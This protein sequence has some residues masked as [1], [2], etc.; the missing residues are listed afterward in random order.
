MNERSWSC[1]VV[2]IYITSNIISFATSLY[3]TRGVIDT[4][5]TKIGDRKSNL[6]DELIDEE[7]RRSKIVTLSL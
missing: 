1:T 4:T 7:T 3:S 6:F 5:S 2:N